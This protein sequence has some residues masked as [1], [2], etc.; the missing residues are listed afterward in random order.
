MTQGKVKILV[1]W[2]FFFETFRKLICQTCISFGFNR[3]TGWVNLICKSGSAMFFLN[4]KLFFSEMST[5]WFVDRFWTFLHN[6]PD[7]SDIISLINTTRSGKLTFIICYAQF[8]LEKSYGLQTSKSFGTLTVFFFKTFGLHSK[9]TVSM[10][11]VQSRNPRLY[12]PRPAFSRKKLWN[13]LEVVWIFLKFTLSN[14]R[15]KF[16]STKA[17]AQIFPAEAVTP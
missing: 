16:Q 10:L 14:L 2:P 11:T 17:D 8:R 4:K 3:N 15:W 6:Y 12:R 9:I 5:F 13:S 1:F 7:K